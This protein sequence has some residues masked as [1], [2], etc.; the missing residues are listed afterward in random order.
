MP[1]AGALEQRMW[2]KEIEIIL[3]RQ[4]A[5][6]LAM[7]MFIVDQQGDLLYFNEPAEQIL[8]RR[9]EET[10]WMDSSEWTRAFVPRDEAGSDIPPDDLPLMRTLRTHRPAHRRIWITGNDG[11][12]RTIELTAFPLVGISDRF[13]GAV[14]IFWEL[15][16]EQEQ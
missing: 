13:V 8:G 1:D 4:L 6:Y 10:G 15:D 16:G 12:S 14:S 5:S 3:A 7:P 9:F 11:V 2:R